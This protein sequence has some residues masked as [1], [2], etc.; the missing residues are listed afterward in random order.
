MRARL[1]PLKLAVLAASLWTFRCGNPPGGSGSATVAPDAGQVADAGSGGGGT[2]AGTGPGA[3]PD[4][5]SGGGQAGDDCEGLRVPADP[6]A[7][8]ANHF[9]FFHDSTGV[10]GCGPGTVTGTGTVSLIMNAPHF[11]TLDFLTPTGTLLSSQ[12][13]GADNLIAGEDKFI[14]NVTASATS[15][16]GAWTERGVRLPGGVFEQVTHV[17]ENPL[18]GVVGLTGATPTITSFDS[19][20]AVRWR[21]S[22]PTWLIAALGVDRA[23]AT[24]LLFDGSAMFGA[25]TVAG[26]WIDPAGNSG[27]VFQAL[28][29]QRD[30]AFR[31]PFKLTQRVKSGLFIGLG[32]TWVAQIDSLATAS[33]PAP[34]WLQA[35]PNTRL[36]M[37]HGGRGYA[38]LPIEGVTQDCAQDVEVMSPSGQ[39]CGTTR[40]R[41]ASGT[42]TTG[43]ISVGYDGTLV[44]QAPD[45]DPSHLE[46][47]G[48]ATCYW[49]WWPGFFR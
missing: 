17:A 36:H 25:N 16:L 28:G 23:G 8:P 42:C 43:T 18:G 29:P 49:Q 32:T 12:P 15:F 24:L 48:P 44:Q 5:G 30:L 37:T 34:A 45:P 14:D 21:T 31:L 41:A 26:M 1:D 9:T 3:S 35:R 33:S 27:A 4:V 2:D 22:T 39:S 19:S 13:G 20:L 10:D 6:G 47:F 11:Q 40:F 38:V 7:A 46:W